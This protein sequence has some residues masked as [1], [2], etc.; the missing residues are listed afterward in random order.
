MCASLELGEAYFCGSSKEV[1]GYICEEDNGY[2]KKCICSDDLC[3]VNKNSADTTT[4]INLALVSA[5]VVWGS[6][7]SLI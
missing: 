1:E 7:R 6:I 5:A 3:N 4:R 2:M